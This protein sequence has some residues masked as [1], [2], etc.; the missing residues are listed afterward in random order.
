MLVLGKY[1]LTC[2]CKQV[3][4]F[5][6]CNY[7][8]RYVR[9]GIH[10]HVVTV[11]RLQCSRGLFSFVF[12][13]KKKKKCVRGRMEERG[14]EDRELSSEEEKRNVRKNGSDIRGKMAGKSDQ[15]CIISLPPAPPLPFRNL[16]KLNTF[17]PFPPTKKR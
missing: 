9:S 2:V 12:V 8:V 13:E 7:A 4:V 10:M 14:E 3:T 5:F 17:P 6:Q 15:H 16:L 1:V 11:Y